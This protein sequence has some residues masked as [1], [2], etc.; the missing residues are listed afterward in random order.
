MGIKSVRISV[1]EYN[2]FM[3]QLSE[4]HQ[5]EGRIA[6]EEVVQAADKLEDAANIAYENPSVESSVLLKR[7]AN[8]YKE[9]R[10]KYLGWVGRRGLVW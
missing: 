10:S 7:A 8:N 9:I 4:S 5:R 1:D 3:D 6:L 2:E